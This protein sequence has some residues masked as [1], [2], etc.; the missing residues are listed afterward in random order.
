VYAWLWRHLP[1]ST[2]VRVVW[3]LLIVVGVVAFLFLVAFPWL[4]PHLP[5]NQVTVGVAVPAP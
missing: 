3:C 1:G 2:S 5:F 4:D